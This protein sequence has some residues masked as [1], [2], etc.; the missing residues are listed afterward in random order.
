[1]LNA[2]D[3]AWG[4]REYKWNR[5]YELAIEYRS[6]HSDLLV[7]YNYKTKSG[8]N[9]GRWIIDTRQAYKKGKLSPDQIKKLNAIDMAWDASIDKEAIW[10]K[11]YPL[12]VEYRNEHGDLLV[13]NNYKTKSG[14]KLGQWIRVTRRNYKKGDLSPD[15]IKGLMAID[16]VWD[17]REYEWDKMC[18]LAEEYR[19]EH[20]DL[21]V[22][23]N[24]KIKSG[25]NLGKWISS[26]RIAYKSGD[27]SSDK[28]EKLNAIG[29]VWDAPINK[30]G[31]WN[32]WYKLAVEYRN[33]HGDL[34]VP[35]EYKTKSGEN[36]GKWI[37]NTRQAYKKG[38]LSQDKIKKLESI[39]M[40][41]NTK[42]N[43]DD[44]EAYLE[45]L[46]TSETP[47]II[48]K[49]LNKDILKH[50]SLLELQRKI[51]FLT[52][53]GIS[54]VDNSGKLIDIF[55]MANQ[56]IQ[57]KYGISLETIIN[58]YGKGETRK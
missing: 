41:W 3:M 28:I 43:K 11:W 5:M 32:K 18:K 37:I 14:E 42:A 27:L 16:M 7:P 45:K 17:A 48:D 29:M 47:I 39:G 21:L 25:E 13:P 23:N 24:Y 10:N 2:I 6:E 56:D 4:S 57:D 58:T 34:L 26:V 50:I 54:P 22:P 9:L 33:E 44:I 46:K 35:K 19:N 30:E 49:K 15:Q 12:A 55:S 51:K 38:D 1:M 8:E 36:L 53:N 20:G 40:V 52:S 31:I